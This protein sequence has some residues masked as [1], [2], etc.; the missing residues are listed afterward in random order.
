MLD[1]DLL[2][3]FLSVVDTGGFRIKLAGTV[4]QTRSETP[5]TF[6]SLVAETEGFEPSIRL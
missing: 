1:L 4:S 2:R 5:G 3:S 6:N